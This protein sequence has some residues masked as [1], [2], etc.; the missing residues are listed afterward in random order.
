MADSMQ[1][2]TNELRAQGANFVTL[3][4]TLQGIRDRLDSSAAAYDGCWGNDEIGQKIESQYTP[5]RDA[6]L[7]GLDKISQLI[8]DYSTAMDVSASAYEGADYA[9]S[10]GGGGGDA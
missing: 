7:A 2:N 4:D 9:N 10:G 3:A 1:V 8:R 5:T 6:I